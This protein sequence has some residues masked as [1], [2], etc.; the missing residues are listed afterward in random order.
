[1][2]EL[3]ASGVEKRPVERKCGA[4]SAVPGV[5]YDTV[6]DGAEMD[7]DLMSASRF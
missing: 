4:C 2:D 7:T 3:Q 5:T 1:M 6:T